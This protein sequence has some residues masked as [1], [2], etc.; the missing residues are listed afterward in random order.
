MSESKDLMNITFEAEEMAKQWRA[1]AVPIAPILQA[2]IGGLHEGLHADEFRL[3]Q[4]LIQP[5]DSPADPTEEAWAKTFME[6]DERRY[7]V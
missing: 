2:I 7:E 3:L 6:G 4:Y 5:K 1:L